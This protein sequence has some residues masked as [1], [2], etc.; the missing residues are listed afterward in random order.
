MSISVSRK[1]RRAFGKSIVA[2]GA[3]LSVPALAHAD[4]AVDEITKHFAR[5]TQKEK[6]WVVGFTRCI[7]GVCV[8]GPIE[9]SR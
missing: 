6:Q 1:S 2:V 5:L 3:S 7:A 8:T 9:G 4:P